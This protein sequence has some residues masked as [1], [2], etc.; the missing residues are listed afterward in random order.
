MLAAVGEPE[1]LD[2]ARLVAA[3]D[4]ELDPPAADHVEHR[5]QLGHPQ[6]MPLGQDVGGLAEPDATGLGRDGHLGHQRVGAELWP[7]GLKVVL[8]HEVEVVAEL[9]G[10]HPLADLVDHDALEAGV[11]VLEVASGDQHARGRVGDWQVRGAVLKDAKLD[12]DG[13]PFYARGLSTVCWRCVA[14]YGYHPGQ[15]QGLDTEAPLLLLEGVT[16]K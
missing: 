7:F 12:H 13:L 10:Q 15:R 5:A 9:L 11:H 4:P 6:R 14:D 16:S 8:G 2:L 3:A 1:D